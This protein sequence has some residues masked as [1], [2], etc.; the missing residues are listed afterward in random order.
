EQLTR[1][2]AKPAFVGDEI[3]ASGFIC[4]DFE[5]WPIAWDRVNDRYRALAIEQIRERNPDAVRYMTDEQVAELTGREWERR[6]NQLFVRSAEVVREIIPGTKVGYYELTVKR[7]VWG[8][9]WDVDSDAAREWRELNEV[10]MPTVRAS[11]VLFPSI[12]NFYPNGG[13]DGI[14]YVRFNVGEARRLADLANAEDDG[15]RLVLPFVW[16]LVHPSNKVVPYTAVS[17]DDAAASI[18]GSHE[19]GADGIAFWDGAQLWDRYRDVRRKDFRTQVWPLYTKLYA[20][21]YAQVIAL[22]K[23]DADE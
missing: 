8:D 11:D 18:L 1:R 14:G 19:V 10:A 3:R 22:E 12:Y 2:D 5:S 15:D 4:F 6:A 20:E 23:A 21:P 9:D 17:A 13:N 7:K 16:A